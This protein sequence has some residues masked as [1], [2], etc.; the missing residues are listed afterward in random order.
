MRKTFTK[1]TLA[2]LTVCGFG[3]AFTATATFGDTLTSEERLQYADWN[4]SYDTFQVRGSD[5]SL[6]L[7]GNRKTGK[8][9]VLVKQ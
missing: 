1:L 5:D 3:T 2:A 7:F 4:S 8:I 6:D 9:G